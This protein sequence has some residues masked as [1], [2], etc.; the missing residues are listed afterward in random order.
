MAELLSQLHLGVLLQQ[1]AA[2]ASQL[3][4]ISIVFTCLGPSVQTAISHE[5]RKQH[6]LVSYVQ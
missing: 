4:S 5:R 2:T 1:P 6:P 3:N